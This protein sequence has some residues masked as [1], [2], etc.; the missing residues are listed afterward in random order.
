LRNLIVERVYLDYNATTPTKP[1]VIKVM[2]EALYEHG[3]PSS[4]HSFGRK[5][6]ELVENSRDS[7]AE[8]VG[9][10]ATDIIFTSGGTESNN[11]AFAASG[12][13]R[14]VLSAIE[15]PSILTAA[16]QKYSDVT[17]L[18]VSQD[19][20]VSLNELSEAIGSDGSETLVSIM[21]A[22]NETGVVEPIKE[23]A[24]VAHLKGALFHCD[25]VQGPG[26]IPID[27]RNLHIDMLSIS[28]HKFGGPKGIGALVIS[29]QLQISPLIV[30]GG[31]ERGWRG[32]TENISG[33]AGLGKAASLAI[34][35]LEEIDR[36]R[37]LRDTLE[38]R[39]ETMCPE[40]NIFCSDVARLPNTSSLNM[41]GVQS[42]TQVITF[43]LA[44][45]AISAGSACSSGKVEPS[46]V[47]NAMGAMP[48]ISGCTIRVSMGWNSNINDIDRFTS[49]WKATFGGLSNK[50][51]ESVSKTS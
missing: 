28:G 6:R 43:D 38:S 29:P 39:I 40:V 13:R 45:I 42:D 15:H 7:V 49:V 51:R 16:S 24:N 32:G 34:L 36:I 31:Q 33:I 11:M 30:G 19:G 48:S 20:L 4:V 23:L 2:T 25:A 1:E 8:L 3:N 35:D 47:L 5:A 10:N 12:R 41:P 14:L 17:I 21:L 22:N 9:A 26:R 37:E 44:G 18:P 27:I 46:H 50:Y